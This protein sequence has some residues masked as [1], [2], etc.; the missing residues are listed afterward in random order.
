MNLT[1]DM[2]GLIYTKLLLIWNSDV[3]G[4]GIDVCFVLLIVYLSTGNCFFWFV[5]GGA[6]FGCNRVV[7]NQWFSI[8]FGPWTIFLK[9]PICYAALCYADIW[10]TTS[11]NLQIG[12][13]TFYQRFT[14]LSV[15]R[16]TAWTPLWITVIKDAGFKSQLLGI[17]HRKI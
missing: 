8:F 4:A 5:W 17:S 15:D 7:I 14:E 11:R 16:W 10:W 9:G 3:D 2:I 12:Q 13:W 6:C 1:V